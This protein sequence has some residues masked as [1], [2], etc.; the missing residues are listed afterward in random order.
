MALRSRPRRTP[1]RANTTSVSSRVRP[2]DEVR[3]CTVKPPTRGGSDVPKRRTSLLRR[4]KAS[5]W[6]PCRGYLHVHTFT[7][8]IHL[9]FSHAF[10]STYFCPAGGLS[11]TQSLPA[12][13]VAML[14]KADSRQSE[15]S[16]GSA[17][18]HKQSLQKQVT[19]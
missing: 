15:P 11:V 17:V 18:M 2:A 14:S 8:G 4:S 19:Q 10:A 9:S 6:V 5:D 3:S 12:F 7:S 16:G 13:V 1:T